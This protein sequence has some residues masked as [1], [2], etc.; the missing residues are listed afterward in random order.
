[1]NFAVRAAIEGWRILVFGTIQALT[2]VLGE[3]GQLQEQAVL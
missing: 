3:W 1:M 2:Q